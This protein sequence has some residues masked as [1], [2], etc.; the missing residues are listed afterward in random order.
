MQHTRNSQCAF[1]CS[2]V[3]SIKFY[4]NLRVHVRGADTALG[5]SFVTS[6]WQQSPKCRCDRL[7]ARDIN[8]VEFAALCIF[9]WHGY[10]NWPL[11]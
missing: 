8:F 5:I 2:A 10:T 11:W 6:A 9:A 4:S 3:N 7:L 1:K